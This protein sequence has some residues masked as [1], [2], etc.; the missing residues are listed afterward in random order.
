MTA[1]NGELARQFFERFWNQRDPSTIE[2]LS[3]PESVAYHPDGS[4]ST[5]QEFRDT[6][7]AAFLDAFPDLHIKIEDILES[8]DQAVVRW[9]ASGTHKGDG[10]GIKASGQPI[11]FRGMTWFTFRN[12]KITKG[13]NCWD[14]G[15]LMQGLWRS[16]P[17]A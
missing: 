16:A 1:S 3:A 5:P 7:Y 14:Y 11:E 10:M 6:Q 2:D 4:Q 12:G 13:W 9:V 8:R 15:G 17:P